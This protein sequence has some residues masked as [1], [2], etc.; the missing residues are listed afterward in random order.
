MCWLHVWYLAVLTV[1]NLGANWKHFHVKWNLRPQTEGSQIT[2]CPTQSPS[3]WFPIISMYFYTFCLF[4]S[5]YWVC[6]AWCGLMRLSESSVTWGTSSVN[7]SL[8]DGSPVSVIVAWPQFP[9]KRL[10]F[11]IIKVK[12]VNFYCYRSVH[13]E[14]KWCRESTHHMSMAKSVHKEWHW[15]LLMLPK[16]IFVI[17]SKGLCM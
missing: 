4:S 14:I 8:L 1:V 10:C 3:Y 13:F 17:Q 15:K 16:G 7:D 2:K 5:I 9:K 12:I 11:H 6:V